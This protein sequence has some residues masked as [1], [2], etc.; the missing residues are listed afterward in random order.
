M[1]VDP[2]HHSC[3]PLIQREQYT[4]GGLGRWYWDCRDR[5]ILNLLA[6]KTKTF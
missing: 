4:K 5:I 3:L 6:L 1:P 2:G